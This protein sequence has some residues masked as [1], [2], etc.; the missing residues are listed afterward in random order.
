MAISGL[1]GLEFM[2]GNEGQ[3]LGVS[4]PLEVFDTN[5]DAPAAEKI[6]APGLGVAVRNV[7]AVNYDGPGTGWEE[8]N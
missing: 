1:S 4:P 3:Y 2:L 8:E 6:L 5:V 7:G